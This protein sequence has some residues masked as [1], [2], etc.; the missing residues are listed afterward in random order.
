M[1]EIV[2]TRI[3]DRLI[4]GQVM[5]AWVKKTRANQILIN[6]DEVAKDDF[7][8]EILKMSAPAGIDIVVKGQ[9]DAVSFL[10]A[11]DKEKKRLIILVKAPATI[12]AIVEKGIEIDKLVVGGMGAK[13]NRRVLYKNISAS[14]EERTTFKKLIDRGIPVV[15]HII[16]DQKETDLSK[17]L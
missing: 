8:S 17:Y 3:D 15:I 2:L 12:A 1:S 4:H 7:M 11:Q 16:P 6:D 9:V 13:A 5:T 10:K 14:D